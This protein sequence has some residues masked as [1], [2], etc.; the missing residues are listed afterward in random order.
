MPMVLKKLTTF[1]VVLYCLKMIQSSATTDVPDNI[2]GYYVVEEAHHYA[3]RTT[4]IWGENDETYFS[5]KVAMSQACA[6]YDSSTTCDDH[7]W[8]L[9]WNKLWGKGRCGYAHSHHEDSDRFVFRRCSD[10][11]CKAYNGQ[12]RIQL[13]GYSYDNGLNPYSDDPSLLPVFSTLLV[14]SVTYT[15][16]L[17]MDN[18]GKTSYI[19]MTDTGGVLETHVVQ[20]TNT[21]VD[22]FN[23]GIVDGLYFGGSCRA[24]EVVGVEYT[25]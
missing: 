9:D 1:V 23:E 3:N 24:P 4:L 11:S 12:N 19:L 18:V 21:C 15:L 22:N 14:P 16:A 5:V 7:L 10:P 20:H 13:A 8:Y 2:N 6:T 25:S 17:S